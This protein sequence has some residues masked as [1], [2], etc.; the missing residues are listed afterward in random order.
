MPTLLADFHGG[1]QRNQNNQTNQRF[2]H[3]FPYNL[4]QILLPLIIPKIKVQTFPP[5]IYLD[6]KACPSIK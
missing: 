4:T 3:R 2:R 5:L 1:N 6:I